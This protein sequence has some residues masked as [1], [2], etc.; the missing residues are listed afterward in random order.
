MAADYEAAAVKTGAPIVTARGAGEVIANMGTVEVDAELAAND[1][2]ALAWL[3]A[4]HVPVDVILE[5]DDLDT[6]GTPA[7]TLTV[8]ILNAARDDLTANTDFLTA[9]TAAQAGG[10]VHADNVKGLQL[11]SSTSDRVIGAKVI[12]AADVPAAGTLKLTVLSRADV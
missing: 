9:S 7:I 8:G 12:T 11:A 4:G 3:P 1:T 5:A 2:V 10:A 6:D